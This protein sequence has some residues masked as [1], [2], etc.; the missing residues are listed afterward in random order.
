VRSA[1]ARELQLE[2]PGAVDAQIQVAVLIKF[3]EN[4]RTPTIESHNEVFRA[5]GKVWLGKFGIPIG[6]EVLDIFQN[7]EVEGSLIL[8]RPKMGKTETAHQLFIARISDAQ[9]KR[10]TPTLIPAYYRKQQDVDTW[11]CLS[12]E[13]RPLSQR[14]AKGWLVASNRES[15]LNSI[16]RRSRRTFSLLVR[17]ADRLRLQPLLATSFRDRPRPRK[18]RGINA[19]EREYFSSTWTSESD[20]PDV[21]S[22]EE[23]M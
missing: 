15:L 18:T 8:A 19:P 4:P 17:R 1:N 16:V 6:S 3:K 21:L 23:N 13:L 11:F 12:S 22:D 14:E 5:N 20:L 2:A 7:P 9:K 10:P